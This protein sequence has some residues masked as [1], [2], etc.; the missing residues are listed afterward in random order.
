MVARWRLTALLLALALTPAVARAQ[1]R[2]ESQILQDM[3]IL[4]EQ[5]QQLRLAVAALTEQTKAALAKV[6]SQ[7]ELTRTNHAN[8]S[9]TLAA[10]QTDVKALSERLNLY[11]QQVGRLGAEIPAIRAGMEQQQKSLEKLVTLVEVPTPTA[12]T[13]AI[14]GTPPPSTTPLPASPST[15]FT[16]AKGIF[17][18]GQDY[19]MAA[20]A[21]ED[22]LQRFPDASGAGYGGEAGYLMGM[23]YFRL[24]RHTPA[25]AAFATVIDKFPTSEHVSDAWYQRGECHRALGDSAKAKDAYLQTYKQ[26]PDTVAGIRARQSLANMGIVVK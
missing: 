7:T 2:Q 8:E 24:G 5:V 25:L 19:E 16:H 6:E 4:Q 18:S 1:S 23:S 9:Q 21:F 13:N 15:V 20:R 3:R 10:V 17:A 14:T 22:F 12:P 26:F 11:S